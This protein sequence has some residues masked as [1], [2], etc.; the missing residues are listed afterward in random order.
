VALSLVQVVL[1][2]L[3]LEP[4][5]FEAAKDVRVGLPLGVPTSVVQVKE[6][7]FH[8][9]RWRPLA[10]DGCN[11]RGCPLPPAIREQPG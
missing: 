6:Q 2:L 8:Q 4:C 7:A 5:L 10:V 9:M 11:I 3:H 1:E